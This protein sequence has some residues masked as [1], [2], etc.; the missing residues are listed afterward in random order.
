[1]LEAMTKVDTFCDIWP[2]VQSDSINSK[3]LI[4][5]LINNSD[6]SRLVFAIFDKKKTHHI[7][8]S[9]VNNG[10]VRNL[11]E[12]EYFSAEADVSYTYG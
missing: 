4:H 9:L 7:Y 3:P 2:I 6:I 1:M 12:T 8:C 10:L 11:L 5:T